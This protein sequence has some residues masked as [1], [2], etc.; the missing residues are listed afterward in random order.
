MYVFEKSSLW[1]GGRREQEKAT[2]NP[3]S[4][5]LRNIKLHIKHTI[6]QQ[7]FTTTYNQ[8]ARIY[9]QRAIIYNNLQSKNKNL[10]SKSNN[11]QSQSKN[12]QEF[13]I[14]EM[15]VCMYACMWLVVPVSS[16]HASLVQSRPMARARPETGDERRCPAMM[17]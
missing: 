4:S 17:R 11:L 9:N 1:E 16:T 14:Q 15:R 3:L 13:T 6:K 8:R 5:S 10:Q 7:E 2:S 12:L